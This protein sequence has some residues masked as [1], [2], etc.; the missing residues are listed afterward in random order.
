LCPQFIAEKKQNQAY[1]NVTF[2]HEHR[3]NSKVGF[4]HCK[5]G[6]LR[7]DFY[8]K[9]ILPKNLVGSLGLGKLKKN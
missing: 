7:E 3:R 2:T 9:P 5:N 6:I 1:K 8:K 4:P